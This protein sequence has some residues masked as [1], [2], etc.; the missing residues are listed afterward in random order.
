MTPHLFSSTRFSFQHTNA[1][2][3]NGVGVPTLGMLGVKSFM[4]TTGT[5]PGQDMLKL[6]IYNSGNTGQFFVDTPSVAAGLL[7]G[8]KA[9]TRLPS[10]GRGHGQAPTATA[11]S[12]PT[13]SS[14]STGS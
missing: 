8:R 9:R 7:L 6:G 3:E 11:R 12:R 2:R 4:Y 1:V 13:A 10:A 5:I 14:R